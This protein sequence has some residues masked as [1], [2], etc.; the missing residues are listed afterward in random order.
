MNKKVCLAILDGWGHGRADS[1]NAIFMAKTPFTD[2]LYHTYPHAELRTDGENVG[3]PTG[4]MGN[5]EVG[6]TNIGAGRIVYQD[7]EKINLAIQDK[8]FFDNDVL[9][10]AFATAMQ[11]NV[12]I[13]F[14]GMVSDGGVHSHTEHLKALCD[15]AA[16]YKVH[17]FIHAFT[18]GRDTDPH[19]GMSFIA[20]IEKHIANTTT[21]IA[22]IIGRYYAMD[23]DNRWER[24]NKAYQLMVNGVGTHFNSAKAAIENNY[25]KNITDEFVEPCLIVDA[26]D[27]PLGLIKE[28]DVVICFNFR[29]DRCRQIS[30]ALSQK[31]F[32]DLNMHRLHLHYC[33]M[34]NYDESFLNVQVVFDK[35]NL[36]MTLGEVLCEN[37]KTQIRIAE[38]EKYPH[39]TFFFN[40]G[41][42]QPFAGE[43]RTMIPSAKVAT[44]DL[45]PEMS[46]L[47]IVNSICNTI[48]IESPDFICLNLANPDMVG[49]TGV[50][51]AIV[52][53][54]ETTDSCLNQL[55]EVGLRNNYSFII[56]ADHGNADFAINDDGSPNTAHTTNPVPVWIIDRGVKEIRNGILA[57]VAPT[58]LK[59]L[60]ISQP[61]LMTGKPLF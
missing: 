60:N 31:D 37:K 44:Y 41:R 22:T 16:T 28:N 21:K 19:S 1:S 47:E 11:N 54:V 14:I 26:A 51:S 5:S 52:E 29:T 61:K 46:A 13:H 35:D 2:S 6:H 45:Q 34:A 56:I 10:S 36:E 8:T 20:E 3:L 40:G 59:L 30:K 18:D 27:V 33:T 39:V 49:H 57:D 48:E 4:Q 17:S 24:I 7:L 32:P 50:F 53:A 23:R 12:N 42:E 9:K 15:M 38:T 25:S 58:I 55:V 43:K